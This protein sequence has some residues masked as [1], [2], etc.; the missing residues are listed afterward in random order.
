[1]EEPGFTN[2]AQ[3][4]VAVVGLGLMGGSLALALRGRCQTLWGLD[5]DPAALNYAGQHG[6]IDAP[7]DFSGA[8]QADILVLASPVRAI[9]D[10]LDQLAS[11]PGPAAPVLV[12]DLGS[13]K[14]QIAEAMRHLPAGYAPVGGHPM[15]GKEVNG[16]AYAEA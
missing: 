1:M 2:L 12:L 10:Q 6:I 11:G 14:T 15:C 4:R 3:A 13:T 9:L 7:T 5:S 16:V 8:T